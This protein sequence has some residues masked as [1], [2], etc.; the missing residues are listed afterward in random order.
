[1]NDKGLNG[2]QGDNC[3]P[4]VSCCDQKQRRVPGR[5]GPTR[6]HLAKPT[7]GASVH[8]KT[9][10]NSLIQG[11]RSGPPGELLLHSRH[12]EGHPVDPVWTKLVSPGNRVPKQDVAT[13]LWVF[14]PGTICGTQEWSAVLQ[15]NSPVCPVRHGGTVSRANWT[16]RGHKIFLF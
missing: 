6:P 4:G 1:M 15:A 13:Q 3:V 5:S 10:E 11:G 16:F 7:V 2:G 8:W 14:R 12:I 9:W